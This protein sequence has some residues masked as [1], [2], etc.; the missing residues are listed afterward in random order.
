M[1]VFVPN[2]T[3]PLLFNFKPKAKESMVR[4]NRLSDAS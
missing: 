3:Y 4:H 2:F 1:G